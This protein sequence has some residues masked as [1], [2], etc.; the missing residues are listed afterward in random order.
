MSDFPGVKGWQLNRRGEGANER[1]LLCGHQ[2][3]RGQ[4]WVKRSWKWPTF[5]REPTEWMLGDSSLLQSGVTPASKLSLSAF[6]C[7][8]WPDSLYTPSRLR[9]SVASLCSMMSVHQLQRGGLSDCI[10]STLMHSTLFASSQRHLIHTFS[11][12]YPL[13]IKSHRSL[14]TK[15]AYFWW[16]HSLSG[17]ELLNAAKYQMNAKYC[18]VFFVSWWLSVGLWTSHGAGKWALSE[19]SA[20]SAHTH[21][22]SEPQLRFERLPWVH[23]ETSVG[24]RIFIRQC[25]KW[26]GNRV[27]NNL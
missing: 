20:E 4:S 7:E 18:P 10:Q 6:I 24:E 14:N 2:P 15:W 8:V 1:A 5:R 27:W 21:A 16:I 23:T 17:A 3:I 12:N 19:W 22:M 25:N 13:P 26:L 11:K 9:S